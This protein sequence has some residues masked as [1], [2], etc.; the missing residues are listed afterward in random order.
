MV[1]PELRAYSI[2]CQKAPYSEMLCAD[3]IILGLRPY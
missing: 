2:H 1:I 3:M